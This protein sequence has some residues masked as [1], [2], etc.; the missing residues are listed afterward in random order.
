MI[1]LAPMTNDPGFRFVSRPVMLEN[2]SITRRE[3]KSLKISF[4]RCASRLVRF[5][6]NELMAV[7]D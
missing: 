4:Y 3:A 2:E 5:G 1:H 7:A 6:V